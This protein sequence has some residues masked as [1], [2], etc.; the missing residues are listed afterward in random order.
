MDTWAEL[1]RAY[2]ALVAI[3]KPE[4]WVSEFLPFKDEAGKNIHHIKIELKASKGRVDLMKL[5][6]GP[7]IEPFNKRSTEIHL[8]SP[9]MFEISRWELAKAGI[10]VFT[11]Q[12]RVPQ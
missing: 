10:P 4:I 9:T 1:A 12:G 11:P 7:I 2:K 3:P 8:M 6:V 5:E